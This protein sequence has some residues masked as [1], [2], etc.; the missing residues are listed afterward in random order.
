[1]LMEDYMEEKKKPEVTREGN[2]LR[3]TRWTKTEGSA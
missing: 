3:L 1:M 2:V